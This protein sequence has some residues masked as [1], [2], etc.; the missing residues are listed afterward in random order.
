VEDR[1]SGIEDEIDIKEKAEEFLEVSK[2]AK[3]IHKNSAIPSKKTKPV[4]C[5]H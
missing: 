1:F 3:G 2:A 4:N 5:G